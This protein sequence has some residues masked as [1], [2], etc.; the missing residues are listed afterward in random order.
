MEG[1]PNHN[2]SAETLVGDDYG[3][4]G[5]SSDNFPAPSDPTP[6]YPT[7]PQEI[8]PPAATTVVNPPP[9]AILPMEIVDEESGN[10]LPVQQRR[11]NRSGGSPTSNS[12]LARV[13][14]CCAVLLILVG[15]ALALIFFAILIYAAVKQF[16]EM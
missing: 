8:P 13:A 16:S 15:I 3:Y 5:L 10:T 2:S 14:D 7:M 9:A 12:K 11:R 1:N 4:K 6:A